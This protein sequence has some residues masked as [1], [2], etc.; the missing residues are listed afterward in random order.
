MAIDS[1]PRLNGEV[2]LLDALRPFDSWNFVESDPHRLIAFSPWRVCV[3][4][5]GNLARQ[6][7][8]G[9]HSDW[10]S[11]SQASNTF[12]VH[13]DDNEGTYRADARS[14]RSDYGRARIEYVFCLP[15]KEC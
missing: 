1:A 9:K 11:G 8:L 4:A 3:S 12:G 15:I 14:P 10:S 2:P 6:R 13:G 5:P 7:D